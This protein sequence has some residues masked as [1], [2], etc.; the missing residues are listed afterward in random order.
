MKANG[1]SKTK[2][3]KAPAFVLRAERAFRRVAIQ[4]RA[5]HA[6]LDLPLIGGGKSKARAVRGH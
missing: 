2:A 3:A 1:H 5:E 4:V 6:K